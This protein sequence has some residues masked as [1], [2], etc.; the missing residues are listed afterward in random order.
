MVELTESEGPL[1]KVPGS[2]VPAG[3]TANCVPAGITVPGRTTPPG[4][5]AVPPVPIS[6]VDTVVP[7][8]AEMVTGAVEVVLT[9]ADPVKLRLPVAA[10]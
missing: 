5:T 3:I 7:P 1:G 8:D 10:L 4:M 9:V 6:P 2:P